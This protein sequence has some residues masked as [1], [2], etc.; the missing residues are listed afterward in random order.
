MQKVE[1]SSPFSRFTKAPVIRGFL[2]LDAQLWTHQAG[3]SSARSGLVPETLV[4]KR[5]FDC[6]LCPR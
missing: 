4:P 5:P 3:V 2:L 1:G 6:A